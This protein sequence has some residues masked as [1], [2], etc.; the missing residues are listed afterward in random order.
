MSAEQKIVVNELLCFLANKVRS[1]TYDAVMK[2]CMDFYDEE[3][4]TAAKTV[5]LDHVTVPDTDDKKRK[6]IGPNKKTNCMKDIMNIFLE[7]TVEDVPLF[8][9]NNLNNLP[10]ISMDNFDMSRIIHD[11]E[12]MKIQLKSLQEVQETSLAAHATLCHEAARAAT[13]SPAHSTGT[14]PSP[15]TSRTPTGSP[16]R[17]SLEDDTT[18]AEHEAGSEHRRIDDDELNDEDLMRLARIQGR[19]PY[20]RRPPATPRWPPYTATHGHHQEDPA[21]QMLHTNNDNTRNNLGHADNPLMRGNKPGQRIN[22]RITDVRSDS[23]H[24][25]PPRDANPVITGTSTNC[26]LRAAI[27]RAKL[28][29]ARRDGLFISRLSSDTRASDLMDYIRREACLNLRCDPLAT[30]HNSYRSYYIHASPRHHALLLKPGMWPK[31]V[32]VKKFTTN[33]HK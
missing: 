20:E 31:D 14:P 32:I 10:P 15:M 17:S 26:T 25:R 16:T 2:L 9:A 11:M 28:Q 33:G 4:V 27:P 22:H 13:R 19:L 5:L 12:A 3:S 7:L 23:H 24:Q 30:R 21:Q 18:D 29:I 8:V 1:M 6:R